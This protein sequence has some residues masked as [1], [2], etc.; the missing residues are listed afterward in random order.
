M[1]NI[2]RLPVGTKNNLPEF[3]YVN[4]KFGISPANI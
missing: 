2:A 1:P 3:G 4:V